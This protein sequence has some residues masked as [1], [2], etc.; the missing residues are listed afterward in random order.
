M[1]PSRASDEHECSEERDESANRHMPLRPAAALDEE[2]EHDHAASELRERK[3][4]QGPLPAQRCPQHR[5][6]FDV[7]AAQTSATHDG[8]EEDHATA[9]ESAEAGLRNGRPAPGY[10]GEGQR[11][12]KPRQS[13]D[14]GDGP[15]PQ[16]EHHDHR[17]RSQQRKKLPPSSCPAELPE[18]Q[19]GEAEGEPQR[20]RKR[21]RPAELGQRMPYFVVDG[22]VVG[23]WPGISRGA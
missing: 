18:S 7:P 20:A 9:D 6:E 22:G 21:E 17:Q 5:H 10:E 1:N 2:G 16:V 13:Q 3:R 14:V 23:A 11:V 4:Y 12:G 8:N 19:Q 15:G